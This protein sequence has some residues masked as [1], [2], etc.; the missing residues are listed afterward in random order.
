MMLGKSCAGS[1]H[2][3]GSPQVTFAA[4][5]DASLL[6]CSAELLLPLLLLLLLISC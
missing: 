6:S 3:H 5:L 1:D 4:A 2:C